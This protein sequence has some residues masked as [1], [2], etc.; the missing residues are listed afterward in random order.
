MQGSGC[1]PL[2]IYLLLAIV[3]IALT[4]VLSLLSG[5]YAVSVAEA[6]ASAQGKWRI[7][8]VVDAVE[9]KARHVEVSLCSATACVKARAPLD[10]SARIEKGR[11]VIVEGSFV[12][13]VFEIESRLTR[14]RE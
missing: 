1:K 5:P 12:D 10:A 3:F 9:I 2:W 13:G 11:Q 7:D 6:K 14:C 8:A 4:V